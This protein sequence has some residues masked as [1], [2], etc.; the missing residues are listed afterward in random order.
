MNNQNIRLPIKRKGSV[1]IRVSK[2]FYEYLKKQ[3]DMYPHYLKEKKIIK[4]WIIVDR[5]MNIT[6][7]A[8]QT[9]E[10]PKFEF[11]GINLKT[12]KLK[13]LF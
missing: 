4:D 1:N 8:E 11:E 12:K 5:I 7:A 6:K 10:I 3:R 9:F 13:R 2:E